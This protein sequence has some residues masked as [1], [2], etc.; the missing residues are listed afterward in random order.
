MKQKKDKRMQKDI[1]NS[2]QARF[3]TVTPFSK[4]FSMVLFIVM[5]FVGGVVGYGLHAVIE[6]DN[7]VIIQCLPESNS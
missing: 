2:F 5:P 4:Y 1:T 6:T 7:T 3:C